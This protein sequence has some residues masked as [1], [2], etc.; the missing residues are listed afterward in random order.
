MERADGMVCEDLRRYRHFAQLFP[1]STSLSIDD[2]GAIRDNNARM[3]RCPAALVGALCLA[4]AGC[5]NQYA[6]ATSDFATAVA[7]SSGPF[8]QILD[9]EQ[10]SCV[11][12][13]LA[14]EVIGR[15]Q[16]GSPRSWSDGRKAAVKGCD[17]AAQRAALRTSVGQLSAYAKA[18]SAVAGSAKYSGEELQA[19]SADVSELAAK[20]RLL[21]EKSAKVAGIAGSLV[22][23]AAILAIRG[24][25]VHELRKA[26][27]ATNAT[28]NGALAALK[29]INAAARL[30]TEALRAAMDTV[31]DG[32]ALRISVPLNDPAATD[33]APQRE[34]VGRLLEMYTFAVAQ[35]AVIDGRLAAHGAIDGVID[36]LG[37]AHAAL[38]KLASGEYTDAQQQEQLK[39]A[40]TQVLEA[41]TKV[42]ELKSAL[43]EEE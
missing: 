17:N 37:E 8:A 18:L 43:R 34:A 24:S 12:D 41:L 3:K 38:Y 35:D 13:A 11:Q 10:R 25:S 30:R 39:L 29:Q 9:L 5:A 1:R 2:T 23:D 28:V 6:S 26:I 19:L 22:A 36:D 20:A 32:Y 14:R 4:L 27:K 42:V 33:S 16:P 15:E 40:L 31:I 21:D 7:A